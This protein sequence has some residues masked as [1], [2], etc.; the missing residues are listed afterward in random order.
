MPARISNADRKAAFFV[1]PR[2]NITPVGSVEMFPVTDQPGSTACLCNRHQVS[3][4]ALNVL[5]IGCR[6]VWVSSRRKSQE[7]Q[8]G[9]FGQNKPPCLHSSYCD[10]ERRREGLDRVG[11]NELPGAERR[12]SVKQQMRLDS[13]TLPSLLLPDRAV[14]QRE[15]A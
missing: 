8:G 7:W 14:A 11:Y 12:L 5:S 1:S 13:L 15:G 4:V 9:L 3:L 6:A 10:R 2:C